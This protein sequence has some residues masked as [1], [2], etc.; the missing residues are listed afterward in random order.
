MS[1]ALRT[2][3]DAWGTSDARLRHSMIE[4]ACAAEVTYSDP[5]SDG[6]LSG[7]GAVAAY[8]SQFSEGA[9]GWTATVD[10]L[11]E[12][13][14]FLRAVVAFGGKGPD[15]SDMTQHGTYFCQ[16]DNDRLTTIAG[17]KG[18]DA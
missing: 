12:V 4:E 6:R 2:F 1:D 16:V 18:K 10:A 5:R 7:T 17:F 8:V 9:P 13:N 15:G 14:G 11:D 3:F